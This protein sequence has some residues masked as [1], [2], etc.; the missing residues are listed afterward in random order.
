M[1]SFMVKMILNNVLNI[2]TMSLKTK[3]IPI[4]EPFWTPFC[5]SEIGQL[6]SYFIGI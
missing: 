4:V 3:I 5:S 2:F 1:Y 6:F